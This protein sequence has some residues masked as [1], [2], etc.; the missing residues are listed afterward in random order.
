MAFTDLLYS[1]R[2]SFIF[3]IPGYS[4]EE[5]PEPSSRMSHSPS[6]ASWVLEDRAGGRAFN[7]SMKRCNSDPLLYCRLLQGDSIFSISAYV[8][9][10]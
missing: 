9:S 6:N 1:K 10:A 8:M 3:I 2:F 7:P 4:G 5:I